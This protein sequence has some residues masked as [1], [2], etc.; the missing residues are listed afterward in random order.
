[1][2]K[3][4]IYRN[5]TVPQLIKIAVRHF[6]LYIR[7]RD[8]GQPCISCGSYNTSDASHYFSAGNHPATRFD[9]NNVHL[10]CRKCNYFLA[11]NLIPYRENLIEKIGLKKFELL[12]EK[13]QKSKKTGY[14][15]DRFNLIELIE[16]YKALNK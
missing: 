2:A 15:W 6:H 1:M 16:K 14:K 3:I 9:E 7:M 8:Q 11:G 10:A 4:N 13:I 5:K 12:E